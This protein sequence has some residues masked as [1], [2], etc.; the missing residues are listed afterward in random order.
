MSGEIYGFSPPLSF[1]S[2]QTFSA[3]PSSA[4][5]LGPHRHTFRSFHPSS[6]SLLRF[7]LHFHIR[8]SLQMIP[9]PTSERKTE[10]TTFFFLNSFL[11]PFPASNFSGL[12]WPRFFLLQTRWVVMLLS[13]TGRVKDLR[14]TLRLLSRWLNLRY[15]WDIPKKCWVAMR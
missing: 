1:Q 5:V 10:A 14:E 4:P 12:L 11:T 2:R 9:P 3:S 6:R 7:L 15:L 8:Q 13:A